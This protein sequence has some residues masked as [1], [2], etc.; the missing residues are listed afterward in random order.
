VGTGVG[1]GVREDGDGEGGSVGD[2][3]GVQILHFWQ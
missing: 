3:E 1:T 2:D